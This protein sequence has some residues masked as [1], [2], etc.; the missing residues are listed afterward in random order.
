CRIRVSLLALTA[1]EE[2]GGVDD[3]DQLSDADEGARQA[4]PEIG[5]RCATARQQDHR[6]HRQPLVCPAPERDRARLAELPRMTGPSSSRGQM[7]TVVLE[8]SSDPIRSAAPGRPRALME[9]ENVTKAYGTTTAIRKVSLSVEEGE[10]LTLL[11]PSGSGK[12]TLLKVVA[13]FV[14]L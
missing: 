11:G 2:P 10:I 5:G 13:G 12:S 7:Q 4:R 3:R 14:D 1:S 8:P 6:V 9:L